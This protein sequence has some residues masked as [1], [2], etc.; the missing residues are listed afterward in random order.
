MY[1]PT[2]ALV[3]SSSTSLQTPCIMTLPTSES[4]VATTATGVVKSP[5]SCWRY[6]QGAYCPEQLCHYQHG[7]PLTGARLPRRTAASYGRTA[8]LYFAQGFCK[9][10]ERCAFAHI[11]IDGRP[12]P[13]ST[14]DFYHSRQ[15]LTITS[16][17][18]TTLPTR[19]PRAS[20]PKT[21]QLREPPPRRSYR[22][23]SF[24]TLPAGQARPKLQRL[25]PD[26]TMPTRVSGMWQILW[27]TQFLFLTQ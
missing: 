13:V 24:T 2:A 19:T 6:M 23:R 12:S 14:A 15:R 25:P 20:T 3:N 8:C 22:T 17:S 21:R 9:Y 5:N 11:P 10:G 7:P 16:L 1:T 27:A 26:V 18:R 4:N